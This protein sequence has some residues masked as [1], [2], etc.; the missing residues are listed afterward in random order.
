M[1]VKS[2]AKTRQDKTEPD[3]TRQDK[4]SWDFGRFGKSSWEAKES[5]DKTKTREEKRLERKTKFR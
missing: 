2:Q 3:K 1:G 5:Q 4:I